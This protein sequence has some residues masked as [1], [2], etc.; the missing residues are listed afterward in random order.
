M[1]QCCS[2]NT[3][4]LSVF[5]HLKPKWFGQ[6]DNSKPVVF[7]NSVL[8]PVSSSRLFFI[9][10]YDYVRVQGAVGKLYRSTCLPSSI[11]F[12]QV[13]F[14][15]LMAPQIASTVT[16]LNNRGTHNGGHYV[17]YRYCPLSKSFLSLEF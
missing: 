6:F 12:A 7:Q 5:L 1:L 8:Q 16:F 4:Y 15:L 11:Y 9:M 10:S 14:L 13:G 3:I 17:M 2:D